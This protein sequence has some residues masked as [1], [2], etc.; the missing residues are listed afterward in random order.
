M[1]KEE[2]NRSMSDEFSEN[3][4]VENGNCGRLETRY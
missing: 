2:L 4:F 3:R 1:N